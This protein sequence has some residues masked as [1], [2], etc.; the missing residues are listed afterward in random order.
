MLVVCARGP[1][2]VLVVCAHG[3]TLSVPQLADLQGRLE[4]AQAAAVK[5]YAC[6][7]TH[8]HPHTPTHTHVRTH[9]HM[10]MCL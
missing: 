4:T 2:C 3:D 6:A 1:G 5:W 8:T 10:N 7:Y 9:T